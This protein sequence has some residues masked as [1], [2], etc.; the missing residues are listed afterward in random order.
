[1]ES[2]IEATNEELSLFYDP[3]IMEFFNEATSNRK[4]EGLEEEGLD[5]LFSKMAKELDGET[6]KTTEG[7]CS[8]NKPR[9]I[10]TPVS[11]KDIEDAVK[12]AK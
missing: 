6:V 8:T 1:M 7:S 5:S 12:A 11:R 10:S 3:K 9:K 4:E 2:I